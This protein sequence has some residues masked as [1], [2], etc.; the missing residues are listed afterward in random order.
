[1]NEGKHYENVFQNTLETAY[2]KAVFIERFKDT[3]DATA[4]AN[5][6]G[7]RAGRVKR[8]VIVDAQPADFMVTLNGV[9]AYV[10]VKDCN[11]KTSFPFSNITTSQMIAAKR[12]VAAKGL[13]YFVIHHKGIWHCVPAEVILETTDRKSIRWT[14]LE[15]YQLES[16]TDIK[17]YF[18]GKTR[19]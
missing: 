6:R 2:K 1:M 9:T 15:A 16:L 17:R 19:N 13:Y 18:N 11:N 5:A 12:Q 10:E 4:K 14:D 3:A 7:R 8:L